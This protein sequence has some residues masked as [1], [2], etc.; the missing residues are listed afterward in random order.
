MAQWTETLEPYVKVKERIRTATINRTAGES[1]I[2]G[3]AFISDAG[4]STPTLITSQSEFLSTYASQEI[5]QSYVEGLN[6]LYT[7]EDSTLAS[8][9]WANAYR[10]AGSNSMLCVRASKANNTYFARPLVSDNPND[11]YVIRDGEML[12]KVGPFKIAL[13]H[14][15]GDEANV[16]SDGWSI[17]ISGVGIFGNRVTDEGVQYDYFCENLPDLLDSL[18]DT[19]KFL[20]TDYEF[21]ADGYTEDNIVVDMSDAESRNNPNIRCILIKEAYLAQNI[22]DEDD[23]TAGI[24]GDERTLKLIW[25]ETPYASLPQQCSFVG[26]ATWNDIQSLPVEMDENGN[27]T[28]FDGSQTVTTS[29]DLVAFCPNNAGTP[30]VPDTS[31]PNVKYYLLKRVNIG[32]CYIVTETADGNSVIDLNDAAWSGFEAAEYYAVNVFNS[33]TDLKVRIRRFNHNAVIQKSLSESEMSSLNENGPSPY[34]VLKSTLDTFTGGSLQ[35]KTEIDE[36]VLYQDF[37][38]VAVWDPSINTVTSFFNIGNITGRG[39][40]EASEINNLLSMIQLNLPEDMQELDLNYYDYS[41]NTVAGSRDQVFINLTIDPTQYSLLKIS[42]SDL[43]RAL[44]QIVLDEVYTTE[45]LCDLGNTELSYQNY[46]ANIAIND[47]YFYPISTVNSTNYMTIGNAA[48][49]IS[50]NSYKLYMSSPW[51]IDTGTLGWKFY[52]SPAVLYWEAVAKNRRNNR[53]FA[54]LLGQDNGVVQ[55]Q[56]PATEFNKKTRQL[57]LSK[58]INT[59]IWNVATQSWNLNDN[60]TKQTENTIMNDDG[61]SRLMIRISKAMPI[62]LKQYIGKRISETLCK[63]VR[64]TIEYFMENTIMP[65]E[66]NVDGYLVTCNYDEALAR[67]NKIKVKVE[68]RYQRALK[69]IE[70]YNE[71]LEL[72]MAFEG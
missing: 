49:K 29:N 24:E 67:Q 55:Y 4:P 48:S 68:V 21:R 43:K 1:L 8:T 5:D 18:N 17:S 33:S 52:A 26:K 11:V 46:M 19:S 65:M 41:G 20:C 59:V 32:M 72:T 58:K 63:N 36:S 28:Y 50:A 12:K 51:D 3:V 34:T 37:Y 62:I 14:R 61:N 54:P 39:D 44:D 15:Y 35:P 25:D 7:G 42:D 23:E 47:N 60:Y 27:K 9:M 53:E 2:I 16:D 6:Q 71:A 56:R 69:Y 38:E 31:D 45:G 70:V 22:I 57:L 30:N 10:L 64:K 66:Y 13:D 40:M